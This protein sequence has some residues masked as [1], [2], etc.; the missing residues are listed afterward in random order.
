MEKT[1]DQMN[2]IMGIGPAIALSGDINKV[3][4]VGTIKQLKEVGEL[5]KNGLLRIKYA[6]TK[7]EAESEV[8]IE[9]WVEILNMVFVEGFTREEFDNSI[10][11]LMAEA[12]ERFLFD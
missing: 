7:D 9:R 11:E 4:R 12:V 3:L 6:I 5:Y 1:E 10:P 2:L 8:Q